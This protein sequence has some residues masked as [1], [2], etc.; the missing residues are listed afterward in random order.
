M[1]IKAIILSLVAGVTLGTSLTSCQDM[2]SPNSER[3][4]YEVAGDTL[5][6]YWGI[7]RSL[8]NVAE[9]YV[10]LGECRGDLVDGTAYISD[11]IKAILDFDMNKAQDGSC[12]YLQASDYYHVVNSCNAYL[13]QADTALM[14]GT[15]QPYM[16]KEYAQVEAIRAWVYLQ[17]IQV[18]L[19]HV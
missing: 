18:Y 4:S 17:L 7:L 14:T 12:R 13:A 9:R 5:Y 1:K 8:Q 2:L 15:G 10:V 6:S 16:M 19:Y 11:S 3:H